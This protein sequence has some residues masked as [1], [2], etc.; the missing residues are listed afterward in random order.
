MSYCNNPPSWPDATETLATTRVKPFS[1]EPE[2]T[3]TKNAFGAI[4]DEI[5]TETLDPEPRTMELCRVL[6]AMLKYKSCAEPVCVIAEIVEDAII[7]ETPVPE[8][9]ILIPVQPEKMYELPLVVVVLAH[10]VHDT[11]WATRSKTQSC[12]ARRI[13][14]VRGS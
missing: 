4:E 1:A 5:T 6:D 2:G 12:T 11:E 10:G 3:V 14:D 9:V 7:T 13:F 8:R